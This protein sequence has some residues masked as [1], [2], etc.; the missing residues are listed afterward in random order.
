MVQM[1][2]D[3]LFQDEIG[4]DERQGLKYFAEGVMPSGKNVRTKEAEA[5]KCC[6]LQA[7]IFF[8]LSAFYSVIFLA[9]PGIL[10]I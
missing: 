8:L 2:E 1:N 5:V 3:T 6:R 9:P 10:L 4:T 7:G